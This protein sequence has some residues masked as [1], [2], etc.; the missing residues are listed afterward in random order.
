LDKTEHTCVLAIPARKS[1]IEIAIGNPELTAIAVAALM[2][3][4]Q[5]K[6][7]NPDQ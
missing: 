2:V 5:L 7:A 4:A 3:W 1:E 6:P